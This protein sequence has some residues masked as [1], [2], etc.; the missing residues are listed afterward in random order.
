MHIE[1][2]GEGAKTKEN[3]YFEDR[4][5]EMKKVK[6]DLKHQQVEDEK[7]YYDKAKKLDENHNQKQKMIYD[8]QDD[9]FSQTEKRYEEK[10]D[11]MKEELELKLKVDIHELEER[12]NLHINELI[13]NHDEA[14]AEL[15]NYYNEITRDNLKMI[16]DHKA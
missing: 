14:F 16:K 13:K 6:H 5:R 7:K 9:Q 15:K 2:D 11:S 8:E 3:K 4:M 1:D 12:K 10:L